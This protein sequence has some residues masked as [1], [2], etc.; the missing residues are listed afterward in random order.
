MGVEIVIR[1]GIIAI[2]IEAIAGAIKEVVSESARARIK[3]ELVTICLGAVLCPLTK[4]NLFMALDIPLVVPR[5]DWLGVLLGQVLT[6]TVVSRGADYLLALW[7][8]V[9]TLQRT[10]EI[11]DG[12]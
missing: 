10:K 12:N 2:L 6:G 8:R 3:W 7:E 4:S 5:V 9:T 11:G 1:L